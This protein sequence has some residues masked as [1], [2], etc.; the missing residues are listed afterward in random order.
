MSKQRLERVV[1][2]SG[3]QWCVTEDG[4]DTI[5]GAYEIDAELLGHLTEW[6][7]PPMAERLRHVC[8]KSWVDVEDFAAA[9]AVALQIHAGKFAPL[10]EGAFLEALEGARRGRWADDEFDRVRRERSWKTVDM[11]RSQ[12]IS[13]EVD[14][15]LRQRDAAGGLPFSQVPDPAMAG[16]GVVASDEED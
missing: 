6:S 13:R 15:R 14:S 16:S 4:L 5:S 1:Y 10:P 12:E 11:Q 7:G 8:E 2:W 3:R 9:F